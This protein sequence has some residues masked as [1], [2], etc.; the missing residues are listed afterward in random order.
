MHVWLERSYILEMRDAAQDG[1]PV[2][3]YVSGDGKRIT[4]WCGTDI[5]EVTS[6]KRTR[7]PSGVQF[8]TY[9]AFRARIEG[10]PY[11][12]RSEGAGMCIGLRAGK[13]TL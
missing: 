7:H 9:Y 12:G 8:A 3:G 1:R 6:F 5:G 4:S 10:R 11:Y 2:S 13:A